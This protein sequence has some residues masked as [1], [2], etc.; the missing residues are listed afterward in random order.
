MHE[1]GITQNI[2]AIASDHA[3]GARVTRISLE[4]G[5]LTAIMPD[6]IRFCFDVCAQG[7]VLEGAALEIL[8]KPGI[9]QCRA[10]G[11][12]MPL[13]QPFGVCDCGSTRLDIIQ[14]EALMIKELETEMLCA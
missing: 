10:C 2:V 7:T 13:S 9:G 14:G 12:R 4:I 1:F 8:E 3:Q 11:H 6:A 5:Q